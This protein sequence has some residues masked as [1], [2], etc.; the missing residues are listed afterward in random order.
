MET[1]ETTT[2]TMGRP[3]SWRAGTRGRE[4]MWTLASLRLLLLDLVLMARGA[5]TR[6]RWWRRPSTTT[7]CSAT[8]PT[9][10]GGLRGELQEELLHRVRADRLQRDRHRLQDPP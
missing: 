2:A 5:S 7:W 3:L 6:W 9:T 4:L 10:G 1:M 8:T